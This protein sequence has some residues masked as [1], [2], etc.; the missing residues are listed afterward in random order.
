M[1]NKARGYPLFLPQETIDQADTLINSGKLPHL[2][3]RKITKTDVLR[4]AIAIGLK[5]LEKGEGLGNAL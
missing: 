4:S 2:P 3:G 5:T 1:S